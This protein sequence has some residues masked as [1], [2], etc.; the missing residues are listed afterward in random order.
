[1]IRRAARRGRLR[2]AT[3][4]ASTLIALAPLGVGSASAQ[5]SFGSAPALDAPGCRDW[6]LGALA[7]DGRTLL[8]TQQCASSNPPLYGTRGV[9]HREFRGPGVPAAVPSSP[10]HYDFSDGTSAVVRFAV[11]EPGLLLGLAAAAAWLQVLCVG[12]RC[13]AGHRT[14]AALDLARSADDANRSSPSQVG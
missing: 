7:G 10:G 3:L 13:H 8:V 2:R 4:H 12:R 9:L 5:W 11:P 6:Q 14:R 1:M